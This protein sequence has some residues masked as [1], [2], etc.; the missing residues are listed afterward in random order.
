MQQIVEDVWKAKYRWSNAPAHQ[1]EESREDSFERVVRGVY[2][3]DVD[4]H[5]NQALTLMKD[6]V[7]CPAGRIQAGAGT[8][9]RVTLINCFVMNE[10]ADSMATEGDAVGIMDTLTNAA[11][12]SQMGGGIGMDFS[13]IRPRGALVKRTDS[14]STGVLPFMDMWDAMCKTIMSSGS[15]RGAMMGTLGIEHPD[16]EEFIEAKHEGGR[17]RNFNVSVLV[18][19]AFMEA[20]DAN[21]DWHLYFAAE[22]EFEAEKLAWGSPRNPDTWVYKTVRARELWDKILRSTYEHAE[23]GVIFIDRVNRE[24]NLAYC[25]TI[26]CTNPCGEQPLPANGDCNLGAIN[27]AALVENPFEE[28][29]TFDTDRLQHA[30]RVAVRFL[31]NVLDVTLYPLSAQEEEAKKKRRIGLGVTGLGTALQ[32]LGFRYGSHDA[33]TWLKLTMQKI[34][35]TAYEASAD[36]AQERGPFP[37]CDTAELENRP[38]IKKL[39][40]PLQAKILKQGLRNGVLLTIAPTGTTSIYYD[41][42]SSGIEPTFTWT[43]AR[44]VRQPDGSFKQYGEVEDYGFAKWKEVND[45]PDA[46]PKDLESI[47]Y[48]VTALELRPDEHVEMQAAAQ[49]WVDASISKTVNVPT[50]MS[51]DNFKAVYGLAFQR[52]C[53]GCTTYRPNPDS[54]RGAI[55]ETTEEPAAPA[56]VDHKLP[57]PEM[58]R[59][60]TYQVKWPHDN[61]SMFMTFN[62]FEDEHG[63]LIPFE[64]FVA[65]KI[66]KDAE[67]VAALTRLVSAVFRRGGD[68]KFLVEELEQVFAPSGGFWKNRRYVPSKVALIGHTLARFMREIGYLEEGEIIAPTPLPEE[69]DEQVEIVRGET[70]PACQAPTLVSEGGCM[71]CKSCGYSNCG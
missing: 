20:V 15:R 12:T 33:K 9:K 40:K 54:N 14:V 22:P 55:L 25:E 29:A 69:E 44:N 23:P 26:H 7:W 27:L 34:A 51:F 47:D 56:L 63:R 13:T 62:Y 2:A 5:A 65:S 6:L 61:Y 67:W 10:I 35:E 38:F 50:E 52:G 58:L 24:N 30:A 68:V 42:I 1:A 43:Y 37:L 53:K 60:V 3:N 4:G 45:F 16:I 59:G 48:M 19:D 32:M 46:S 36:L 11:L 70:C 66:V 39:P 64:M 57:R 28:T 21:A 8:T 18:T 49:V 41:N 31:D 71:V 17:L